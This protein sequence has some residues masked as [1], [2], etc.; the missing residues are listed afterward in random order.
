[1][2]KKL[3]ITLI[4][5]VITLSVAIIVTIVGGIDKSSNSKDMKFEQINLTDAKIA[6][7]N[8]MLNISQ[9]SYLVSNLAIVFSNGFNIEEA[10]NYA[11]V[12]A[13]SFKDDYESNVLVEGSNIYLPSVYLENIIKEIFDKDVDLTKYIKKKGYILVSDETFSKDAISLSLV[14]LSY[15][16]NNAL[17]K[18]IIEEEDKKLEITYRQLNNKFVILEYKENI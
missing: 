3:F 8:E 18:A 10:I 6:R 12:Y 15:S 7:Y 9:A 1:M 17:Y 16:K 13:Y 4:V 5:I 11:Y 2:N 14:S